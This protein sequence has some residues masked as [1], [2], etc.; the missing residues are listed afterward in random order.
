MKAQAR[1]PRLFIGVAVSALLLLLAAGLLIYRQGKPAAT[2][3]T[4]TPAP[5]PQPEP[6]P[7][8][9]PTP[10]ADLT[11]IDRILEALPRGNIAFNAPSTMVLE[12]TYKIRLLL[13]SSKS[14]EELQQE[15]EHQVKGVKNLEGARIRIAS[16]MEARLTGQ[17]FE[18]TA[19]TPEAQAV[20]EKQETQWQWDVK[21]QKEGGQELHLTL[22]AVLFV[23]NSHTV[24]VIRTFDKEIE[25]Q[26][27]LRRR[28]LKFVRD[29]SQWIAT[30]IIIPIVLW[31]LKRLWSK[32]GKKS[33]PW[34]TP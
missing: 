11:A 30:A 34:D 20:S 28:I 3:P 27:T 13:S 26:V 19:V 24:R 5:A 33:T 32:R 8:P 29:N 2:S 25:V 21:P 12:D 17:N 15:L 7:I 16:E 14:I 9:S 1:P 6:S 4:P 18:I 22:S 23:N 10:S 31:I